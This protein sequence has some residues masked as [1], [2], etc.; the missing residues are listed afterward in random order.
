MKI[1]IK[2]RKVQIVIAI[3]VVA[4]VA[5]C[6]YSNG[7]KKASLTIDKSAGTVTLK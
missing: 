6:I 4:I 5:V 2:N 1:N 3:I 7:Q